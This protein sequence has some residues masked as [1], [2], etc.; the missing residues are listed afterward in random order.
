MRP[1]SGQPKGRT[2]AEEPGLIGEVLL[3]MQAFYANIAPAIR[4]STPAIKCECQPAVSTG[5]V[6]DDTAQARGL[7][8]ARL[9]ANSDSLDWFGMRVCISWQD[10]RRNS[11]EPQGRR[12]P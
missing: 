2:L 1:D 10:V 3:T 7:L 8:F 6:T 12:A 9:K 4:L 11:S 5:I